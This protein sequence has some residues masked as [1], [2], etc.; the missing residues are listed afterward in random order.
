MRLFGKLTHFLHISRCLSYHVP[1]FRPRNI[2]QS[3]KLS[4]L[5]CSAFARSRSG[6]CNPAC[7][8]VQPY[9]QKGSSV[10]SHNDNVD[11]LR[12]RVS[13]SG[14]SE[15][16]KQLLPV[17]L[18]TPESE[19]GKELKIVIV[20]LDLSSMDAV[21]LKETLETINQLRLYAHHIEA[22]SNTMIEEYNALSDAMQEVEETSSELAEVQ[23][24]LERARQEIS[25]ENKQFWESFSTPSM[26]AADVDA[27]SG[28]SLGGSKP[29]ETRQEA[30]SSCLQA[31]L[32]QTAPV[33]A[34]PSSTSTMLQP[35][36]ST[37][38]TVPQPP[39]NPIQFAAFDANLKDPLFGDDVV[40]EVHVDVP[41]ELGQRLN[42]LAVS[43][44]EL[45]F[46]MD[47]TN[48]K[49]ALANPPN[50][51]GNLQDPMICMHTKVELDAPGTVQN[52]V[53][54]KFNALISGVVE[55][56]KEKLNVNQ[57]TD[58][59]MPGFNDD[60]TS[61]A[62]NLCSTALEK[63]FSTSSGNPPGP[64]ISD[65]ELTK[66]EEAMKERRIDTSLLHPAAQIGH[67]AKKMSAIVPDVKEDVKG[68]DGCK[69]PPIKP[70]KK[71][72]GKCP[73]I[74]DPCKEDP[75]KRP[76]KSKKPKKKAS[77]ALVVT[78]QAG[79]GKKKNSCGKGGGGG[80]KSNPCAKKGGGGKKKKPCNP[81]AK[82]KKKTKKP[83]NKNAKGKKK[84]GG[85]CGKKGGDKKKNPCGKKGGDKKKDPC[86]KLKKGGGKKDPCGKKDKGGD[87]KKKDPC[88]KFKKGGKGGKN[89]PCAKKGGKGGKK[90]DPCAKFKKGGKGGKGGGCKKFS[91]YAPNK[92]YLS[93]ALGQTAA[94]R[95]PRFLVY[96]TRVRRNYTVPASK[97]TP[98]QCPMCQ[99]HRLLAD[100]V[101]APARF[102]INSSLMRRRFG[103]L[104]GMD[105]IKR[106]FSKKKKKAPGKCGSMA[107]KYPK[108]RGKDKKERTGLRTDCFSSDDSCG[109]KSCSGRCDKV[110]FPR[111]KCDPKKKKRSGKKSKKG[112]KSK[113]SISLVKDA[114][115]PLKYWYQC[116]RSFSTHSA[117]QIKPEP[118]LNNKGYALR[119]PNPY[120]IDIVPVSKPIP[121]DF[122]VLVRT[123]SVAISGSDIHVYE[124]GNSIVEAITLG[125]DATGYVEEVGRSVRNLRVGD[126]VVME[127]A[128]SCGI[129]DLCKRG[130][131]NMC[132]GMVYN[133]FMTTYQTHPGDLCH[134]LDPSISMDEGTLVQTLA[135]GCQ[136]CL[137][138]SVTPTSNVL[139][140]GACPTAVSAGLCAR[141]MGAKSVVIGGLSGK[142][143][144]AVS[145]D[146]GFDTVTIDESR[147]FGEVL[148]AMYCKF[149]DWP[150]RVIN[151]SISALTMN[152]AVM[153]L[154]P[155]GI[156]V[157]A[158]CDS[159]CAS[160]NALDVL[161]K[162]IR[163][164]PSFR[165][166]NMYPTALQL[167]K[168][169]RAPMRQLIAGTFPMSHAEEAFCAALKESDEGLGKVIVNCADETGP[170]ARKKPKSF[171]KS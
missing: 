73:L 139:I 110:P 71:C 151:C 84:G 154:Q 82:G 94:P 42:E 13:F 21:T 115:L 6:A 17:G 3:R 48:L 78:A 157:L 122:D 99:K 162:N 19:S 103:S 62:A 61:L 149:H 1:L 65:L 134:R 129:C 125:H 116:Q 56:D 86:A 104:S 34:A 37:N 138:G 102:V 137:T 59:Q 132:S 68:K 12:K 20:P 167:M 63:G 27:V 14:A 161:M 50:D 75:C 95:G 83:C 8:R 28:L 145:R 146:F 111:K 107:Q 64:F 131:Y 45:S 97:K 171:Q 87:K 96:S 35:K 112:G 156:C 109:T 163:L 40:E 100:S 147:L 16:N 46:E 81:N 150:D 76:D 70:K 77:S 31:G 9:S 41:T 133:G 22:F 23:Q 15:S 33:T 7:N 85:G 152:L 93:T 53:P 90:K 124:K 51:S 165:S 143:L 121:T 118:L 80:K 108:S 30:V 60:L 67:V 130:Q 29:M 148:E 38:A 2:Q 160:F 169:G 168:S 128:L 74:T 158:E 141:A 44:M 5:C 136:A 10:F 18:L 98:C 126:R 52:T 4:Q 120:K 79:C 135:L 105:L 166:A 140:I 170:E 47:M 144:E 24:Q 127:S 164:I 57:I 72:P 101:E 153:A 66:S 113:K 159:E 58:E 69:H 91:T 119:I 11:M 89:D 92:R 54:L 43:S 114:R 88:A 117:C 39:R 49:D 155:S 123:G 32:A 26:P 142:A 55:L 36:P 25:S 106:S